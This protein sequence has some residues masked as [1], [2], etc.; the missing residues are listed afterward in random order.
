VTVVANGWS[1]AHFVE[2]LCAESPSVH[3]LLI[4]L[5]PMIADWLGD[6]D[7]Y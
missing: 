7:C 1:A 2:W 6:I 5:Y 4:E 3:C